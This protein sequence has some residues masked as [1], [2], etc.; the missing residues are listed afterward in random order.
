MV[1]LNR[2]IRTGYIHMQVN[3]LTFFKTKLKEINKKLDRLYGSYNLCSSDDDLMYK[4]DIAKYDAIKEMLE[5]NI[6][7][8]ELKI[9]NE[10]DELTHHEQ[11]MREIQDV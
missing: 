3:K 5:I 4:F 7:Y 2:L 9:K 10:D 6:E 8:I 11:I 1:Q